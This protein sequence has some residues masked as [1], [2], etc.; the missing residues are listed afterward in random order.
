[1]RQDAVVAGAVGRDAVCSIGQVGVQAFSE[2]TADGSAEL[3][4]K[5]ARSYEK[6]L[7]CESVSS[8]TRHVCGFLLV[9]S[10]PLQFMASHVWS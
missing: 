1:M 4:C 2:D 9:R 8:T 7:G 10:E 6:G 3:I 5:G